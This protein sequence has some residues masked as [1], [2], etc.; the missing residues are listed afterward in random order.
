M[1]GGAAAVSVYGPSGIGKSALVRRF[2]SQ[3]GTRD[4]VV[5]LSGRCYENESVPLQGARRR[6]RRPEP[7]SRVDSAPA[8]RDG[9]C[10][11][12]CRR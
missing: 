7:L 11:P 9:C 1:N 12:M 3:F 4:D 10:R 6:R 5:V 2:L 8:G